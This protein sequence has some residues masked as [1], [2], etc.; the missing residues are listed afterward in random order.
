MQKV[1]V[2][3]DYQILRKEMVDDILA[4][5]VEFLSYH[6]LLPMRHDLNHD[7]IPKERDSFDSLILLDLFLE[8]FN[9]VKFALFLLFITSDASQ[10]N[11]DVL[12][13]ISFLV[14]HDVVGI[15]EFSSIHVAKLFTEFFVI[16]DHLQILE[17]L[18]FI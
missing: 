8:L 18:L 3:L 11:S 15:G 17:E 9:R 14:I 13:L 7:I 2:F 1:K 5:E 16:L 12:M 10:R 6:L 4:F